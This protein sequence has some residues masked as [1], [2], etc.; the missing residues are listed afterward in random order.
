MSE[1]PR[2]PITAVQ[3]GEEERRR[4]LRVLD[5][6]WL[7]QGQEVAAFEKR[8]AE[9]TH[10]TH[11]VATTSC[12][13]ALHVAVKALGLGPGD[14]V[15]VPAFTWVATPNA[16]VHCGATPVF[17]DVDL[18]TFNL[19]PSQLEALITPRTVGML[20]VHLFGLGADMA[21]VHHLA[22]R[23][24][25]WV[26]E[27]AACA[28]GTTL[29]GQPVGHGSNAACVS[30]HPRKSITTGE[31]G[32]IVTRDSDLAT[33]AQALRSHGAAVSDLARHQ[34][35]AT[36]AGVLLP[37]FDVFGFNYRMTDL[38]A[39]IG[40]GQLDHIDDW[41]ARRR[42]LAALY[43][44]QLA[45]IDWIQ[46]P[47]DDPGHSY[48]SFACL[49]RPEPP[50]LENLDRLEAQRDQLLIDL[51]ANGIV[52][53]QGT[54]APVRQAC[55]RKHFDTRPEATPRAWMAQGLSFA[56]PLFPSMSQSQIQRVAEAL[57]DC[58]PGV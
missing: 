58:A 30:F 2:I 24:G 48:Q 42:E 35:P 1:S 55:Y 20:P 13:S 47:P 28:L 53:R 26:I 29:R 4:V 44:E 46:C 17:C 45:S 23:H 52:T 36:R 3:I 39:A 19:D 34:S 18:D 31:G 49:F 6:G 41:I 7:V 43:R 56:L 32:M 12:T 15:I 8:V 40:H 9:Y 11:A 27:D 16:V 33:R 10:A 21:A 22:K 25:L 51:D 57:V 14:E 37:D 54:H 50:T 5:S 38:Q